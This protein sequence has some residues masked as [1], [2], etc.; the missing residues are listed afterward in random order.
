M[1]RKPE[2]LKLRS[3]P[4]FVV[5]LPSMVFPFPCRGVWPEGC[6]SPVT[7]W[8][9]N[10]AMAENSPRSRVHGPVLVLRVLGLRLALY[11]IAASWVWGFG[12]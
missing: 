3:A 6:H 4:P 5:P 11:D 2:A 8:V 1:T 7:L 9:V 12:D 10:G